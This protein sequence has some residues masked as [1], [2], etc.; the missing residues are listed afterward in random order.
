MRVFIIAAITI[1]TFSAQAQNKTADTIWVDGICG[2]CEDRI[3]NALD[4]KG[5][6][7]AEWDIDSQELY[8]VYKESKITKTQICALVND[9]G[10]Y[11]E[12]SKASD[13]Q[14]EKVHGC[15]L[16]RDEDVK[17]QPKKGAKHED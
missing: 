14:Y 5:V 2:M 11:T 9:A 3:E 4:V 15:C 1:L 13:E 7:V 8:V 12:F 6:W 10:H 17:N 16:Y